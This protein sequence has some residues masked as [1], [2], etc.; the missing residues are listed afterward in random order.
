MKR[1]DFLRN[2]MPVGIMLPSLV[3]GLSF[4]AFGIESPLAL[5]MFNPGTSTDHVL[6]IIQLSG[7]N[8]G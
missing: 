2:T 1:R 6:V 4:K 5:S 7:G 8:D 3:G